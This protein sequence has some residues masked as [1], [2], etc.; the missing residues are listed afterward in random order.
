[1]F[2]K[3]PPPFSQYFQQVIDG[4]YSHLESTV[5]DSMYVGSKVAPTGGILVENRLGTGDVE[6]TRAEF[7]ANVV[8]AL[9]NAHHGYF[10]ELDRSRRPSRYL[11]LVTGDLP[12]TFSYLGVLFGI[13]MLADPEAM[14]RWRT[15]PVGLYD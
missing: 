4:L 6:E 3:L 10:T 2:Q 13:G 8:R 5:I 14:I 12:E 15:I 1:V 7:T 9:R 11:A